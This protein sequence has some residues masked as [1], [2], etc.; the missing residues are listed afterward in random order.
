MVYFSYASTGYTA[1]KL[2]KVSVCNYSMITIA[3]K[4]GL[5]HKVVIIKFETRKFNMVSKL[6]GFRPHFLR[7]FDLA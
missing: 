3:L 4:Y 6:Q 5:N 1:Y 2:L 7:K